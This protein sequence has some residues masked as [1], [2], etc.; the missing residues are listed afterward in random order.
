MT[1]AEFILRYLTAIQPTVARQT[2]RTYEWALRC[3]V[4]PAFGDTHLDAVRRRDVRAFVEKLAR[5]GHLTPL[6]R[7]LVAQILRGLLSRAVEEELIATNPALRPGKLVRASGQ[8]VRP[9]LHGATLRQFLARAETVAPHMFALFLFLARTGVRLGEA[10]GMTWS[11]IDL[12][13]RL[14]LVSEQPWAHGRVTGLKNG[15]THYIDLSAQLVMELRRQRQVVTGPWVFPGPDGFPYARSTVHHHFRR[16]RRSAGLAERVSPHSLR[17]GFASALLSRGE[18]LE[19]V[20]RAL[21][22]SD[23]RL[24]TALYGSHLPNR[25]LAAVDGLDD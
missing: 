25:R 11:R 14:A 13:A 15:R 12:D 8:A 18:P 16:V 20:R 22:H 4:L 2:Y 24:T 21:D 23:P 19:Y 6:T 17:H 3:Y 7:R 10:L 5:D 1:V 9:A